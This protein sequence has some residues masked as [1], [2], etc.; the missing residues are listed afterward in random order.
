M[1]Y[2]AEEAGWYAVST[3]DGIGSYQLHLEVYRPGSQ[4]AGTNVTQKIFLDFD[5]QRVNTGIFG[6]AGVSTLSPLS[7]FLGR[8]G[9]P[10]S[11]E[12]ELIDTV[13]ATVRENIKQDLVARGLN[14][15][16]AVKVLNSR[17]NKDTFGKKNVS[18]VIV[19]GT[20]A[21]S[22]VDT[23]GIA[24]SI[25]PGNYGHEETA[26][27]LL[28]ILS[29]PETDEASLNAY[30]TP[31]SDRIGFIGTALGNVTS[32]ERRRPG[33]AAVPT[34]ATAPAASACACSCVWR[35]RWPPDSAKLGSV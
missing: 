31:A 19:G 7:T 14:D 30:L 16:V 20:I 17:D 24:Q 33:A 28:D 13:V 8:W 1:S 21:Q 11:A 15:D 34:S 29:N 23:I 18:R 22:G 32:H 2:V 26:L 9:L 10:A 5:G 3:T 12:D 27:V 6:G 25:D 4:T 35:G